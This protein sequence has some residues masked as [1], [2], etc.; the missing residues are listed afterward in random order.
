MREEAKQAVR[1]S[2]DKRNF[3]TG[4]PSDINLS[5]VTSNSCDD[6]T[7]QEQIE[8]ESL[9]SCP[10]EARV[11][12]SH[13]IASIVDHKSPVGDKKGQVM[14]TD[15]SNIDV[16]S[17]RIDSP[18]NMTSLTSPVSDRQLEFPD[19]VESLNSVQQSQHAR[20]VSAA[21]TSEA[22]SHN[23]LLHYATVSHINREDDDNTHVNVEGDDVTGHPHLASTPT[24][25]LQNMDATGDTNSRKPP[26]VTVSTKPRFFV[27]SL[28][29]SFIICEAI[30]KKRMF[31]VS[32]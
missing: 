4:S 21:V 18:E 2:T 15:M 12:P 6:V 28:L 7:H 30:V 14:T 25:N 19:K 26:K 16:T 1:M 23:P 3:L 32:L 10:G 5:A 11:S 20:D 24:T 13:E 27:F 22:T 31:Y 17:P 9:K 8:E 29:H